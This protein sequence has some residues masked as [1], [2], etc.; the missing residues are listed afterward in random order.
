MARAVGL[1]WAF[2]MDFLLPE[3]KVLGRKKSLDTANFSVTD[4]VIVASH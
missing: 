1:V 3:M 2:S 4:D